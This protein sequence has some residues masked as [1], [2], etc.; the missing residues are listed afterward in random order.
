MMTIATPSR[1]K[2]IEWYPSIALAAAI[3][4]KQMSYGE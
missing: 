1:K 2:I 4:L 3:L